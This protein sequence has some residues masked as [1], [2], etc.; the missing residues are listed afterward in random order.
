MKINKI[1]LENFRI[2]RGITN[3]NLN[4]KKLVIIVG[5]NG[6]GKSAI[7]DAIEWCLTGRI[8][9]YSK[10]KEKQFNYVVN[11]EEYKKWRISCL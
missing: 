4:G 11:N 8:G 1:D 9:R 7:Y 6:N 3:I 5:P 2:Y 10:S